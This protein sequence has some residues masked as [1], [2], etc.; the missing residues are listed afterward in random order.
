MHRFTI[1]IITATLVALVAGFAT[2]AAATTLEQAQKI[3][4]QNSIC[5]ETKSKDGSNFNV[6]RDEVWCPKKGPCQCLACGGRPQKRVRIQDFAGMMTIRGSAIKPSKPG[7]LFGGGIL[8]NGP[9]LG[10][11]GPAAA[12]SVVT[13]P[14]APPPSAPPVIIH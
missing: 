10:S 1:A 13:T 6:G 9:G 14:A 5:K 2:P 7:G 3:C 4:R 12:G 11:Q 8:D